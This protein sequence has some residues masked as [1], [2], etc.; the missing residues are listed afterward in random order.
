LVS[1]HAFAID[2]HH[3]N[4]FLGFRMAQLCNL[5]IQ[6]ERARKVLLLGGFGCCLTNQPDTSA[7]ST[8]Q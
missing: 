4:I 7:A 6:R 2:V 3:G 5:A 8:P 1:L